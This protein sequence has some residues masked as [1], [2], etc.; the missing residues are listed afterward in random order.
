MVL[1]F[2]VL[3]E[4]AS[5]NLVVLTVMPKSALKTFD[6]TRIP[7]NGCEAEADATNSLIIQFSDAMLLERGLSKNTLSAYRSDLKKFT[8]WL[9]DHDTAL[10]SVGRDHVLEFL[11]SLLAEG[12][13]PRTSAR[14][15]SSLRRFYG[16]LTR[17]GVVIKDPTALIDSPKLG[18]PLPRSLSEKDVEKL[19]MAPA[20]RTPL[21]MRDRAMLEILYA[22]GLRVSELVSLEISQL[23]RN[24]GVVRIWGKGNKERLVPVGETALDWVDKYMGSARTEI[25]QAA[26]ISASPPAAIFLSRRGQAMTRQTFW[27]A[28]KRYASAA[29]ITQSLSP[30]TLRH[31]FATHLVNHDADLR[32]VQL[33]LG[34]SDLSTTQ[35]YTHVARERIKDLHAMHHPRG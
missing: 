14:M 4:I 1:Q 23:N 24:Q 31:A 35:I 20:T 33:L 9:A 16:F 21:G 2:T 13:T 26:R 30:H 29:G 7:G 17:E 5:F 25:L 6:R 3:G 8:T 19:L 15:L 18:R 27:Y 32:V 22:C 28:I 34:H 11:S 10:L 12:A